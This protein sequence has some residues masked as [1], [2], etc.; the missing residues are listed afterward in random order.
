MF[1]VVLGALCGGFGDGACFGSCWSVEGCDGSF[2][3]LVVLGATL[4]GLSCP[5]ASC[6]EF[7]GGVGVAGD[8]GGFVDVAAVQQG[9]QVGDG[10]AGV[11]IDPDAGGYQ[12]VECLGE[13]AFGPAV[14]GVGGEGPRPGFRGVSAYPGRTVGLGPPPLRQGQPRP[15]GNSSP[16]LIGGA[17]RSVVLVVRV[18]GSVSGSNPFFN[19]RGKKKRTT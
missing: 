14:G 16:S 12:V 2:S 7:F 5:L 19:E 15:V 11:V 17:A 13:V 8:G 1:S 3:R 18:A 6:G 4:R 10:P 9:Q